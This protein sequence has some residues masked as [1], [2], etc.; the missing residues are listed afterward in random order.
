[1]HGSS[2][3]AFLGGK[4]RDNELDQEN[5]PFVATLDSTILEISLDGLFGHKA[6]IGFGITVAYEPDSFVGA[7]T[8]FRA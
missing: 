8:G 1:M 2:V 3:S 5:P 4:H 6:R 7:G